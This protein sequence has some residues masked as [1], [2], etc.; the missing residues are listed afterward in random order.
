[1][2]E[3]ISIFTLFIF[4]HL[5]YS[6]NTI[7]WK[8]T[9]PENDKTS[10][11]VGTYHQYGESFVKKYPKIEEY[12]SK[13]DAAF[14]ESLTI[15]TL[16]TNKIINSRKTENSITKYF[17]KSQIEKLENYTNKSGLNLYKITPI[18][19]LFKLQQKYTRIICTTVEKN[20]ENDHFDGFLIK[21][22]DKHNVRK[23]G[24]ETLEKQLELLNK[25]YEYFTWKNQRKNIL[26]YFENIN[27]SKPNKNDK[28]NLCGFAEKFKNFD[29]DYQFDKSSNLKISVTER[30]TNWIN[31]VIP[32]LKQKNV[33]IAVGYMHLMYKDGLI[34]Q[35][36]KNGFIVEPENMN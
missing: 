15:D 14:F 4:C 3:K 20:E 6:Q 33:F 7:L 16:A 23:I 34:N 2:K 17:T 30:N 1:M 31:E 11:L 27:S 9:Y 10:Y 12:L 35:L 18:E 13:S 29:L 25:Q 22:S 26:Y 28:E 21:L 19:L 5:F 36:R 24:F 32:Q 8:I